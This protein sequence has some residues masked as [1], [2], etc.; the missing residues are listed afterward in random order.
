[1][2]KRAVFVGTA[3]AVLIAATATWAAMDP[4]ATR[5]AVMKNNGAAMGALAAMA[6]GEAEFDARVANLAVR[7]LYNG[8]ADI[9]GLFPP[10]TET[11]GDT[12]ALPAIWSDAAGFAAKAEAMNAAAA[13]LIAN[14][15]EDLAG[16]QAALGA[17]GQ[18]CQ[19]CHETYRMKKG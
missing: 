15:I 10:G 12:E 6:K 1:M 13:K 17:L 8:S 11:G 3:L 7:T 2:S 19:G 5:K 16:V 18:T 14:P 9:P 4:I